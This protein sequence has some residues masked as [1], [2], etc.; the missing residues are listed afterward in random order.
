MRPTMLRNSDHRGASVPHD[1]HPA[2]LAL[3]AALAVAFSLV[4][5]A[6][7]ADAQSSAED[8]TIGKIVE[9]IERLETDV[10]QWQK[11][12]AEGGTSTVV[13][14]DPGT[15]AAMNRD[16]A[17]LT[18]DLIDLS[19]QSRTLD[20]NLSEFAGRLGQFTAQIQKFGTRLDNLV[21]A[22]DVRLTALE[23]AEAQRALENQARAARPRDTASTQ[24]VDAPPADPADEAGGVRVATAG[25]LPEG[26]VIKR[27]DFARAL[28]IQEDYE[29][30]E[31]AFRAF[32][33]AHP[34]DDLAGNAQYWLGETHYVR[35]NYEAAAR[36]FL[37]GYQQYPQSSK[38]PDFL[39]KLGMT[40][41]ALGQRAEACNTLEELAARF[42]LMTDDIRRRSAEERAALGCP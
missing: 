1:P 42:S 16:I 40:L 20:V 6:S 34:D 39:L 2:R 37:V 5:P 21:E 22:V 31:Q 23:E 12:I 3:A 18:Q 35:A 19:A 15:L 38:A 25:G 4:A 7:P 27:Y 13:L 29:G 33:G 41:A 10:G 8:R 28:L 14:G 9:R 32:I 11:S 17:D 36:E 26:T 24:P 30:A